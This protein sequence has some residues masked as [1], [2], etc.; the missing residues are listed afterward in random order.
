VGPG[1]GLTAETF[2]VQLDSPPVV[3]Q[4]PVDWDYPLDANAHRPV[5]LAVDKTVYSV[6]RFEIE[7]DQS[8][9]SDHRQGRRSGMAR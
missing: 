1:Y 8:G 9:V 7:S 6:H 2:V 3:Q 5:F 4:A